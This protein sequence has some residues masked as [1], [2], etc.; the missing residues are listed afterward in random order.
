[1][2]DSTDRMRSDPLAPS[3][4][5]VSGGGNGRGAGGKFGV[6]NA[7][8]R[9]NPHNRRAQQIRAALLKAVKPADIKA[10]AEKLMEAAKGG[11]RQAFAELLDR[12]IGRPS[13]ADVLERIERLEELVAEQ[14][15][16]GAS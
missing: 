10:A 11:D 3:P 16:G 7:F 13:P 14:G 4:A 8:G 1:M 2:N 9:G 6:G 15:E 5:A 12:T